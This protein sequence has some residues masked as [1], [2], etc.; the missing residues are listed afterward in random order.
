MSLEVA[1]ELLR[2]LRMTHSIDNID[3]LLET[4]LK[5]EWTCLEFMKRVLDVE[6]ANLTNTD[7]TSGSFSMDSNSGAS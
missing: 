1:K 3:H 2:E 4:A 7:S 6:L 5:E